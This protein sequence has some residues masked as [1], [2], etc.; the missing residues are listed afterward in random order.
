MPLTVTTRRHKPHQPTTLVLPPS[1]N[2]VHL[3]NPPLS[4][5][6]LLPQSP[7]STRE[8]IS[9]DPSASGAAVVRKSSRRLGGAGSSTGGLTAEET[10]HKLNGISSNPSATSTATITSSGKPVS[11][12]SNAS[13]GTNIS[14]TSQ[15]SVR[16]ASTSNGTANN[17]LRTPR[18]STSSSGTNS[19]S[20]VTADG[21]RTPTRPSTRTTCPVVG[22]STTH[23]HV[24]A[25]SMTTRSTRRTTRL[26]S[27]YQAESPGSTVNVVARGPSPLMHQDADGDL[28]MRDSATARSNVILPANP[29]SRSRKRR[30]GQKEGPALGSSSSSSAAS[31]TTPA[32]SSAYSQPPLVVDGINLPDGFGS[33]NRVQASKPNSSMDD[34]LME[35]DEIK[36]IKGAFARNENNAPRSDDSGAAV[37]DDMMAGLVNKRSRN[38]HGINNRFDAGYGKAT[39]RTS[40]STSLGVTNPAG[41]MGLRNKRQQQQ[42]GDRFIPQ[43]DGSDLAATYQLVSDGIELGLDGLGSATAEAARRAELEK[44]RRR[45]NVGGEVDTLKDEANQA[46][47]QLLKS[48]LFG[49]I[50]ST[51][52]SSAIALSSRSTTE[53]P[54]IPVH[55]NHHPAGTSGT[56]VNALPPLPNHIPSTPSSTSIG[57]FATI[58]NGLSDST[59]TSSASRAGIR[60]PGGASTTP[61][62]PMR[63]KMFNYASPGQTRPSSPS[64]KTLA[65]SPGNFGL[66]K[67]YGTGVG[68][69]FDDMLSEKYSLS[70]IGKESQKLLLSPRRPTRWMSKTPFKVLDAPDLQDDFYLNLVSWS[71]SNML[72]VGLSPSIYLWNGHSGKVTQLCN[73]SAD[74]PGDG[75]VVTG[76]DWTNRGSVLAVGTNKGK[77]EIWDAERC[78]KIRTMNGHTGRVGALAWN[79]SLLSTGSRDRT[80]LHRDVRVPDHFIRTLKGHGQEVCGLKWNLDTNQLASGG[81]DNKLFLW[82][83]TNDLPLYRFSEHCAAVKAIAWSPHQRGLLASGGGTADRKIRYWNG[84]TGTMLSEWDTGSQVSCC[85][86]LPDNLL[87]GFS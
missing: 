6:I 80:I 61:S 67:G 14:T 42:F 79:D 10:I 62:T 29:V 46:Y 4:P 22:T 38:T 49:H 12:T 9:G 5:S 59:R 25:F 66:G 8:D 2:P 36:R 56:G 28:E 33:A 44:L 58:N 21:D 13:T 19:G 27:A 40:S 31:V 34:D 84:L 64:S 54:P 11:A 32:S 35:D 74:M 15:R 72:A 39:E 17:K 86:T 69:G 78:K 68:A 26:M 37:G 41:N 76:L 87:T 23:P 7:C 71:S 45:T 82:E 63:K 73:M 65:A 85:Q 83:K 18:T 50:S 52:S 16:R 77:V 48:E 57:A 81:N 24:N 30:S 53:P 3:V 70:P 47:S 43:R 75:D 55:H 1:T 60:S 20:H 51:P